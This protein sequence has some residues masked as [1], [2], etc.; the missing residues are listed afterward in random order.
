MGG[1]S[2]AR[3]TALAAAEGEFVA[4]IDSDAEWLRAKLERQLACLAE[5]GFAAVALNPDNNA[6]REAKIL[7]KPFHLKDLVGEVQRLLAA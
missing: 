5:R 6:P 3:N 7:S 2:A 4:L 1:A